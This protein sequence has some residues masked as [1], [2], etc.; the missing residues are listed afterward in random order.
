MPELPDV[1]LVKK[2]LEPIRGKRFSDIKVLRGP[3]GKPR[4]PDEG[5]LNNHLSGKEIADVS[6]RGKFLIISVDGEELIFHFRMTGDLQVKSKEE[7]DNNIRLI[8]ELGDGEQLRFLDSR[9]IGEVYLTSTA[10]YQTRELKLL[11]DLGVEPLSDEFDFGKLNQIIAEAGG[12]QIKVLLMDQK[13]IAG[14]GNIYAD[15]VLYQS[16]IK[17]GRQADNLNE[18]ERR[19]LLGN[20]KQV[21]KTAI[22]KQDQVHSQDSDYLLPHRR[23]KQCPLC[24]GALTRKKIGG[25]TSI[26]CTQ[27]QR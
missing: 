6:R 8:F 16:D 27:H 24:G 14:I 20:I 12:R 26:F 17:P 19:R 1:E 10:N 13:K 18:D 5:T 7:P 3:M 9:N 11:Q 15:E 22:D 25:R 23:S 21:L 4:N 2:R